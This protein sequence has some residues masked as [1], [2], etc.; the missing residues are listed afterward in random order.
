MAPETVIPLW[1]RQSDGTIATGRRAEFWRASKGAAIDCALCYRKCHLEP[2]QA[3]TCGYRGNAVEGSR[4]ELR[5]H[6]V[7]SCVVR[8]QR[9]YQVDLFLTYKPGATSLFLGGTMCTSACTFCMSQELVHA[10]DK[11]PWAVA[12]TDILGPD[13]QLYGVKALLHPLDAVNAAKH[14]ECSQV[15]FGI[16]EPTL[17]WEWTF[18]VARLAKEAGL[19]VC[20]QSNGFT[21]PQAIRKLAP[22]V[23]AVDV[24]PKGSADPEFYRKY[25]HAEGAVPA[26]M[27]SLVEW[28][29]AGVHVVVGDLL[30]PPFMQDDATF[31]R[32]ARAFYR[33]I[34]SDLGPIT[35]VLTTLISETGPQIPE[36]G[37]APLMVGPEPRV[38]GTRRYQEREDRAI[39]I[40]HA[41]GLPY[42]HAK[43]G[44]QE[45][46][47]H[48]C[49]GLLLAFHENC[50]GVPE[51]PCVMA[52]YF[53]PW[54]SH[55]QH[56]VDGRCE[57]CG[58]EV[59]IVA[60]TASE[61]AAERQKVQRITAAAGLTAAGPAGLA[62]DVK[63]RIWAL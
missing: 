37:M 22:Y 7:V 24:S 26:V 61:L 16:N 63:A 40:A 14:W 49:G 28:R 29:K 15:E 57:H 9:G 41:E 8:Q 59:P 58:T 21:S 34:R 10:P 19:D 11:V 51:V 12:P 35:N 42:A 56:V 44:S 45:V 2:G 47:C 23:D 5:A 52:R 43:S 54:W 27:R 46:H 13:S 17:S 32:S 55:E 38:E 62:D 50:N 25:M 31:E 6:G 60:L 48:N 33:Q 4:M 1:H 18:D 39:E 53:C 3:G 30:A 36:K 20:V